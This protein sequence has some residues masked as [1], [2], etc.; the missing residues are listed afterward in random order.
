VPG[1]PGL[2]DD[3]PAAL[4]AR[5]QQ[6]LAFELPQRR[7]NCLGGDI[8]FHRQRDQAGQRPAPMP[9]AQTL[10]KVRGGLLG[11]GKTAQL[12]HG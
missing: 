9:P 5:A 8:Q 2:D 1:R 3:A 6:A 11:E 4:A 10:A 12:L 7:L